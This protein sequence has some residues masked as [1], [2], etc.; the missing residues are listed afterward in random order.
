M[1]TAIIKLAKHVKKNV[2]IKIKHIKIKLAKFFFELSQDGTTNAKF[3]FK[4][5]APFPGRIW[6]VQFYCIFNIKGWDIFRGT[7]H[8][9]LP[10]YVSSY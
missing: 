6:R 4:N 9:L 7:T 10:M 2:K 5:L 1:W 8:D 3:K